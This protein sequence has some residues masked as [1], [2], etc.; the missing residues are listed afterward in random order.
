MAS[1]AAASKENSVLSSRAALI[2][3]GILIF[4]ATVALLCGGNT[5]PC[6]GV[7]SS[8]GLIAL[9][10]I[11]GATALGALLL[12]LF[13][14]QSPPRHGGLPA[15]A[16]RAL[17]NSLLIS[18]SAALGLGIF[19]L[20]GL[21]LGLLGWLNRPVAIAFPTVSIALF[22]IDLLRLHRAKPLDRVALE[23]WLRELAGMSWLWLIPVVSLAIAATSA[24]IMPGILWKSLGDP[25]P[26]DVTSY[27][28][29]VPRE[30]YEGGRIVPLDHN[31][32]SYFPF[33]VEMQYLL[34]MHAT[35][36]PW[37]GMFACQ[38][39]SVGYAGLMVLA[40]LG[41]GGGER[42][43]F[44]VQR[45]TS[46]EKGIEKVGL[47]TFNSSAVGAVLASVVP[48]T[49]MLA[50]VAYVE[51]ALMLYT[52]LA[53]AWAMRA[54]NQPKAFLKPMTIAGVMAGLACG[55]KITA[56][57]MLLMAV[58]VAWVIACFISNK[59]ILAVSARSNAEAPARAPV[60]AL[61]GMTVFVL[62]GSLV[63][64]PWLI[65]NIVWAGNPL[66]PVAMKVLGHGHFNAEQVARFAA[67]HSP[68]DAQKTLS[69]RALIAWKNVLGLPARA[70]DG[71]WTADRE[72]GWGLLPIGAIAIAL[73]YRKRQSSFLLICGLFVFVTWIGFTHLLPRFAV[74]LIPIAAIAAG[75]IQWGR[76]WPMAVVLLLCAAGAGW[77]FIIPPLLTQSNPPP[78][79]GQPRPAFFGSDYLKYMT[80]TEM[81]EARDR[82]LQI[83][84]IGDAQAFLYQVPMSQLHYRSVFDVATD[85]TNPIDAWIGPQ[86]RG[87]PHWLLV[88][89]PMEIDRL[90]Q[91]YKY[92][93]ALPPQWQA[94]LE[95]G[96]NIFLRGDQVPKE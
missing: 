1:D 51:S 90:H 65:R 62:A 42:S 72:F 2:C 9:G 56:V 52:A 87:D 59:K 28:L 35:A 12:R 33:N 44:N 7:I 5:L 73:N 82:D 54:M 39:L 74:M 45:P 85:K 63:L 67:A 26:Y 43:T 30:W 60:A 66:F 53:V 27:H 19:S 29:L 21:G 89:N 70:A 95:R 6:L 75:Q 55:V 11:G 83:A 46:R 20:L 92:I 10:W 76:L 17:P 96:E 49:I 36:G 37:A 50:G 77:S 47:W 57:P 48:W 24:S 32:F 71:S 93:P 25:H 86:V 4:L 14:R 16:P 22:A 8:D 78:F 94:D 79:Q 61:Q 81:A 15:E 68:T 80:F 23:R 38:F 31:V 41:A 84:L 18:T 88:I 3:T 58:P 91:T 69:A 34:L 13:L 40:I 64:S